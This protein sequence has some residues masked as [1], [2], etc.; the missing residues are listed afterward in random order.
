MRLSQMTQ[1]SLTIL[2]DVSNDLDTR[3]GEAEDE[4]SLQSYSKMALDQ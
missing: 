4:V 1:L 2:H 3:Q